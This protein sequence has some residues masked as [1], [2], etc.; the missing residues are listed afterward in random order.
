MKKTRILI[1][2][3]GQF[4]L[5]WCTLTNNLFENIVVSKTQYTNFPAHKFV[6]SNLNHLTD[7]K[8]ILLSIKPDLVINSAAMTDVKKCNLKRNPYFISVK[9]QFFYIEALT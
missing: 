9:F 4:A 3:A 2:G 1:T 6:N 7:L 8:S 5:N